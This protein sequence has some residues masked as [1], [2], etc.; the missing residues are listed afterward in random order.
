[1]KNS[2]LCTIIIMSVFLTT[3]TLNTTYTFSNYEITVSNTSVT[4][5]TATHE[6]FVQRNK[7]KIAHILAVTLLGSLYH[8][9]DPEKYPGLNY[10]SACLL[11]ASIFGRFRDQNATAQDTLLLDTIQAPLFIYFGHKERGTAEF[12]VLSSGLLS[13]LSVGFNLQNGIMKLLEHMSK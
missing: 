10:L 8:N 5:V 11:G 3:K 13:M 12:L 9:L 6:S 7:N 1:M 4:H 2:Y